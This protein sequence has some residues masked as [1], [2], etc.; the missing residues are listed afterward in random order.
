[1]IHPLAVALV[2][3]TGALA[4]FGIVSTVLGKP[5]E[6]PIV[7]AVGVVESLLVAQ[8]LIAAVRVLGGVRPAETSTF[9]IYLLVSVCVLPFFL[10][11]ARA[12]PNRWGGA[13]I[14]VGA[15]AMGVVVLRLLELW[16]GAHV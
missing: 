14:A 2:I 15:V 1:M 4:V 9:L 16:A 12:E 8:A 13:V 6:R 5:P 7:L 11:F 3:L 10:Q